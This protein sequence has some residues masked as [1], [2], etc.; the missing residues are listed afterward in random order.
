MEPIQIQV[1]NNELQQTFCNWYPG[2][3]ETPEANES[4]K[5]A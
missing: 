5:A 1:L 4:D 2:M 3:I